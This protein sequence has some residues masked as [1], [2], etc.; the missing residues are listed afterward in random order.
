MKE[1]QKDHKA[2]VVREMVWLNFLVAFIFLMLLL[3]LVVRSNGDIRFLKWEIG[4]LLPVIMFL[5]R[6]IKNQASITISRKGIFHYGKMVTTWE[7]FARAYVTDEMRTGSYQDNFILNVEHYHDNGDLYK[8]RI[9][10]TNTQNKSEEE[11]VEVIYRFYKASL[12]YTDEVKINE[13]E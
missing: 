6:G 10:L 8:R 13:Q 2:F 9:K 12:A 3:L 1:V 11:I 7:N 5:S 4:L